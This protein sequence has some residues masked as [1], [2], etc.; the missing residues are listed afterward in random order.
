MK[1]Q[2][3]GLSSPL[4]SDIPD[5]VYLVR[6]Q[7]AQYRWH[8]H[9]PS[10]ELS[11]YILQPD[12]LAGGAIVARLFSLPKMLWRLAWFLRDF[13]YNQELLERDELDTRALVGLQG[14]VQISHEIINGR[15]T[16]KL[17]AFAPATDWEHM[18]SLPANP[19]VA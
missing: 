3:H 16:V 1:R 11:F 18:T 17:E 15:S 19:E 6:V 8:K 9:K 14:V 13:H 5:G 2:I 10:Y 12:A 4:S 7:R